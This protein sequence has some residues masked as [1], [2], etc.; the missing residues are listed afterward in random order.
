ML[1]GREESCVH[2]PSVAVVAQL[3]HSLVFLTWPN[4]IASA[5]SASG[6]LPTLLTSFIYSS[7]FF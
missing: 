5:R 3:I 6:L 4:A 2:D 7:E 1:Q